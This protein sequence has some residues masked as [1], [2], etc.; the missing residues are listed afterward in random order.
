MSFHYGELLVFGSVIFW[1]R[2]FYSLEVEVFCFVFVCLKV[3][4]FMVFI[5]FIILKGFDNRI[6][7]PMRI[8]VRI[9][10]QATVY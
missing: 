9:L 7:A 6:L 3:V 10:F 8:G 2:M 1:G 5:F 4:S